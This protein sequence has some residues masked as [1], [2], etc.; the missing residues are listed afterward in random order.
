MPHN[1][2]GGS[3]RT[4]IY[5]TVQLTETTYRQ[6]QAIINTGIYASDGPSPVVREIIAAEYRRLVER[7]RIRT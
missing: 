4:H 3:G 5:H 1:K 2:T 7:G 6:V